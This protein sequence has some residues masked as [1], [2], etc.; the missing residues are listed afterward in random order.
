[1][2]GPS[3][4]AL[5]ALE[6]H[7]VLRYASTF[8]ATSAARAKILA[9]RPS[10]DAG[11]VQDGLDRVR[12]VVRFLG[13][14]PAWALP[15]IPDA[16]GALKR[17]SIEGSVLVPRELA[18][19]GELL[20]AG[21]SL[22]RTLED[23]R[24]PYP[25][26]RELRHGLWVERELEKQIG[27]SVDSEGA[28]LD[29]ASRDL[30]R[31]RRRLAGAHGRLV[32]HLEQY[33]ARLPEQHRVAGASVTIRD[34]RYAIPV[35]REGMRAVGGYVLDES[36]SGATVFVEPPSA[37]ALMNELGRLE[38]REERE[39]QRILR[40]LSDQCRSGSDQLAESLEVL[41][42]V[43]RRVALARLARHW[44]G[45][46]PLVGGRSL[47]IV[48]GRHPLLVAQGEDV[49]PFDIRLEDG[50]RVVVVTGPNTGGK[51]VF[52]KAVGLISALAQSGL[53]PPVGPETRLPLFDCHFADIGDQ[54]SIRDS[55]ST[56]SAHVVV[57]RDIMDRAGADSLVLMD[58]P[59]SGT[60]PGEGEAL[61]WALVEI[62]AERGCLALVTSHL[63][64]LKRLAGPDNP[65]VNA[66]MQFDG[67]RLAPT[68]RLRKGRPGRSYGLV[69]ARALGLSG[70]VLDRAEVHRDQRDARLDDLLA[71]LEAKERALDDRIR[72]VRAEDEELAMLRVE[73]ERREV[74]VGRAEELQRAEAR[75]RARE[76]LLNARRDVDDVIARLK[77][78]ARAGDSFTKAARDARRTVERAA[79][80]LADPPK[81]PA[82]L[83]T[84]AAGPGSAVEVGTPVRL[85]ASG[86]QG[87]VLAVG[88]RRIDV[89]VGA[90]RLRVPRDQLVPIEGEAGGAEPAQ[91]VEPGP[92]GMWPSIPEAQTEIDLRGMR[93]DEA[94]LS[95]Q[96]ALDAAT[97]AGLGELRVIHGVGTGVLKARVGDALQRD[98]RIGGIRRGKPGEGGGGVTV[99]T[100][101]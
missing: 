7:E 87:T 60:D 95:L 18:A 73:L 30:G 78:R 80:E 28:V 42:E 79:A 50:E 63:G 47:C 88:G 67:K 89:L 99:A 82:P 92:A 15:P 56:F 97:V 46:R 61:A 39:V 77:E 43:D 38:R 54:Q 2:G 81:K 51:T 11:A 1:M 53:V 75:V 90:V 45:Y 3:D 62:L 25:S 8:A 12:E 37:I 27:R 49:V 44:Q 34:G 71:N 13:E 74:D 58:E 93:A 57:L 66:S 4:A 6:F 59:G 70:E 98:P 17:L 64:G 68:Y 23:A 10:A 31:I 32:A 21:R 94:E 52:L 100:L 26:L 40:Q 20:A 96:R 5:E 33:L 35:R 85:S 19:V 24:G 72:D 86:A 29:G 76:L 14:R 55:L 9:A 101:R 41:H 84:D 65:V 22:G 16:D 83:G 69:I 36:S 91:G 48:Q